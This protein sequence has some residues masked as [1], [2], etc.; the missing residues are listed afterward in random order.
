VTPQCITSLS[1]RLESPTTPGF[2]ILALC[3]LLIETLQ[4]FRDGKPKQTAPHNCPTP[5]KCVHKI[6]GTNQAFEAFLQRRGSAFEGAFEN[7]LASKFVNGVRNGIFH[8]AE[9]RKWVI[10]ER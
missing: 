8:D 6:S 3:C 2:A 10:C 1:T 5:D 4:T 7:D 9:T